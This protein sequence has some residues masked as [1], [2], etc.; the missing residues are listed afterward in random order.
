MLNTA[1][2]RKF[3]L[4]AVSTI[5]FGS[6]RAQFCNTT[7]TN[8]GE[9]TPTSSIQNTATVSTARNYWTF[10]ATAGCTYT[11][12]TCGLSTMDTYLRIYSGTNPATATEVAF[13]DDDCGTQST[14]VW[15]CTSSG[16]YSVLLTRYNFPS[17]CAAV[18]SSTTISYSRFCLTNDVVCS[19]EPVTCGSSINGSTVGATNSGNGEAQ[20][21]GFVQDQPGVWYVIPGNGQSITASLCT[22]SGWDSKLSVFSGTDCSALTCVGGNDDDGPV[23]NFAA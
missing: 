1:T 16:A 20:S 4:I 5:F 21:C 17:S 14:I 8:Q 15:N 7:A 6:I 13:N 2:L 3:W 12:S 19:A 10:N 22:T 11:F 18:N 23:C 9:I